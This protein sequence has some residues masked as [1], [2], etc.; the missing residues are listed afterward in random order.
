M[1]ARRVR[2][3]LHSVLGS[4]KTNFLWALRSNKGSRR[5]LHATL[6]PLRVIP[7]GIAALSSAIGKTGHCHF[8]AERD[9]LCRRP[10]FDLQTTSLNRGNS[11][12]LPGV[13]LSD[14]GCKGISTATNLNQRFPACGF[15]SLLQARMVTWVI[16]TEDIDHALVDD[17]PAVAAVFVVARYASA[18]YVDSRR[19]LLIDRDFFRPN[20]AWT[21]CFP[22]AGEKGIR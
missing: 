17:F 20:I 9:H 7:V 1:T 6:S 8:R 21:I 3:V 13:A 14:C 19:H 18:L 16:W 2:W 11:C 15:E 10:A 5:N 12:T 22:F 4:R